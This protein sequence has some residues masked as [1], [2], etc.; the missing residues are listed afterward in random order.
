[1]IRS[2]YFQPAMT[3]PPRRLGFRQ[4]AG[5][6]GERCLVIIV[7]ANKRTRTLDVLTQKGQLVTATANCVVA[8]TLTRIEFI[9]T[10]AMASAGSKDRAWFLRWGYSNTIALTAHAVYLVARAL[11]PALFIYTRDCVLYATQCL[12]A[13]RAG[14]E[15]LKRAAHDQTALRGAL[16]SLSVVCAAR[17]LVEFRAERAAR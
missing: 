11:D 15:A 13:G 3:Q 5:G 17:V 16:D 6:Q 14:F 10:D 9:A 2:A 8:P 1:M 12:D 7:A 4:L